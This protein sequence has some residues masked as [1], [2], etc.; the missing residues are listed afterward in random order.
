MYMHRPLA[1]V[2]TLVLAIFFTWAIADAQTGAD[3]KGD[4][5]KA[6]GTLP[7]GW[8]KLDLTAKQKDAIYT[9]MGTY[10]TKIKAL[11]MQIKEL[12]DEEHREMVKLLTDAQKKQLAAGLGLDTPKTDDKK[13]DP[14]PDKK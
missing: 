12:K 14:V 11:E 1:V 7:A 5:K 13:V 9:V 10:K 2:T 6:K 8:K 4:T 3:D